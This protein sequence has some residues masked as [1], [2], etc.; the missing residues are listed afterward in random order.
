M[1]LCRAVLISQARDSQASRPKA[2]L[3]AQRHTLPATFLPPGQIAEQTDQCRQ[4]PSDSSRCSFSKSIRKEFLTALCRS[5][6]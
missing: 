5:K 6:L 3:Q 1:A 4:N 2:F